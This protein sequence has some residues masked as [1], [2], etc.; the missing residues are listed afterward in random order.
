MGG[1]STSEVLPSGGSY[2][3]AAEQAM[4]GAL[5]KA[6]ISV[7]AVD[8]IMVTG[9]GAASSPFSGRHS[10]EITCQARGVYRLF[11]S[12]RTLVDIGGQA[13][14]V[15]RVDE[16]GGVV[17]FVVSEKCA[18]GSARFLEI[19][20]RVLG[21]Q[22]EEMGP[23]SLR[24][25]NQIRFSTGCAVFAESEAVSRIAEGGRKEDIVAG[26]HMA[27]ATKVS[28]LIEMLGME[29]DCALTGGGARNSGLVSSV[30]RVLGIAL[31]VPEEPQLTAALGAALMAQGSS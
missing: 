12:V 22:V 17:N 25:Q 27:M 5:A 31:A 10:S 21:V 4:A 20:G 1:G 6:S 3:S 8:C 30:A 26:V 18:A 16:W 19:L 24:S 13:T 28:N 11:P 9:V 15:I 23:L 2:R 29:L 14:R 7:D